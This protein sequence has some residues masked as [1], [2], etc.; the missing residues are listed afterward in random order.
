MSWIFFCYQRTLKKLNKIQQ[1][2]LSLEHGESTKGIKH[3][4]ELRLNRIQ[5]IVN[6]KIFNSSDR[7][8][9]HGIG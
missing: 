3:Y 9:L 5:Q 8:Y 1:V 7:A 4:E 2:Q 6:R